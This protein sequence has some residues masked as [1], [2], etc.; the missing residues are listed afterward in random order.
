MSYPNK[1][2]LSIYS[3]VMK[4]VFGS[5]FIIFMNNQLFFCRASVKEDLFL[6]K[7]R[8]TFWKV[9]DAAEREDKLFPLP[10]IFHVIQGR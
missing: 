5:L 9:E 2:G 4:S 1:D 6:L 8:E 3:K 7:V 10:T